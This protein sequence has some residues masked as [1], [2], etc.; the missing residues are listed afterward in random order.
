[1]RLR[2]LAE[3][4]E[5]RGHFTQLRKIFT[6]LRHAVFDLLALLCEVFLLLAHNLLELHNASVE[7]PSLHF[8]V[9]LQLV[10][11]EF[12]FNKLL[13]LSV[14]QLHHRFQ[15]R[16]EVGLVQLPHSADGC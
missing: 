7:S 13:D 10:H 15:Q 12:P 2:L 9:R 5:F 3:Y 11:L 16:Q 6:D 1:M 4:V 8:V 14:E